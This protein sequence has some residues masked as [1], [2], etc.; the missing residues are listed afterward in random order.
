[1][2]LAVLGASTAGFSSSPGG[3][4]PFLAASALFPGR[5]LLL[6]L[7]ILDR[8]ETLGYPGHPTQAY[9]LR[10]ARILEELGDKEARRS[11]GAGGQPATS[12]GAGLL[13]A[14]G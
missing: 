6:A 8:A 13:L 11:K 2:D 5:A 1:M 9:H 3:Q 12:H 7:H 14:G 4:G 10:R